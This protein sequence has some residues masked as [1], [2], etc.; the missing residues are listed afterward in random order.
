MIEIKPPYKLNDFRQAMEDKIRPWLN[1]IEE[2]NHPDIAKKQLELCQI[3]KL[4]V[5][6]FDE[7]TIKELREIPD[8]LITNGKVEIGL[9]HQIFVESNSKKK[10]GFFENLCKHVE[11]EIASTTSLNN[12]AINLYFKKG[13]E[14]QSIQ[15]KE[16]I[17]TLISVVIEKITNDR[18]LSNPFVEDVFLMK[19]NR[20]SINA[21]FGAFMQKHLDESDILKAIKKKE[22]L[23]D[24][25]R[26]NSVQ[27]Q[28]LVMVVGQI[29]ESSFEVRTDF[30]LTNNS[31]FDR[32]FVFEDFNNQLF[33]LK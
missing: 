26:K 21:N 6:Y 18:L 25:Y 17:S 23:I 4:L 28:W 15:K 19:H 33:E 9:E 16:I 3:G 5:T 29:N 1:F 30:E 8:F 11:T 24:N 32:V 12:F 10:E 14:R 27:N 2:E 7:F 13:I 20:I 31:K 22:K